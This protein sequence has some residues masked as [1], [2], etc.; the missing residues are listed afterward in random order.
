LFDLCFGGLNGGV[1]SQICLNVVV[2]LAL[3]DGAF[4]GEGGVAVNI[5]LGFAKLSWA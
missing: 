2:E 4:L 1:R 3:R 5:Q